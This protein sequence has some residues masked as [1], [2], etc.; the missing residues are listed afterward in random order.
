MKTRVVLAFAPSLLGL[1][2][3]NCSDPD[4]CEGAQCAAD[5]GAGGDA[6]VGDGSTLADGDAGSQGDGHVTPVGCNT[7]LDLSPQ[8]ACVTESNGLFVNSGASKSG[9]NGTKAAPYATIN[10]AVGAA[11]TAKPNIFVCAGTFNDPVGDFEKCQFVRRIRLFE[12]DV[13][14]EQFGEGCAGS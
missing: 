1:F 14:D 11:S 4:L 9:A 13:R 6:T 3:L 2:L 7:A 8:A 5:G 12:V 10:D